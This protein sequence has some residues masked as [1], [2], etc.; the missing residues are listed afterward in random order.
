MSKSDDG[1]D[2]PGLRLCCALIHGGCQVTIA[3]LVAGE[4]EFEAELVS[5]VLMARKRAARERSTLQ[6]FE[7]EVNTFLTAVKYIVKAT[8]AKDLDGDQE[9]AD[10]P[11][12]KLRNILTGQR[13]TL[14]SAWLI[15]FLHTYPINI[16][17]VSRATRT[18]A[19]NRQDLEPRPADFIK[20]TVQ[21][22]RGCEKKRTTREGSQGQQENGEALSDD[23]EVVS[24]T[25]KGAIEDAGAGEVREYWTGRKPLAGLPT[26]EKGPLLENRSISTMLV[27]F[28]DKILDISIQNRLIPSFEKRFSGLLRMLRNGDRLSAIRLQYMYQAIWLH[29]DAV[30]QQRFIATAQ[31]YV[32]EV[33]FHILNRWTEKYQKHQNDAS[34]AD[35]S[36]FLAIAFELASHIELRYNGPVTVLESRAND[37]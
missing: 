24:T 37:G 23:I 10:R 22:L 4:P 25:R 19:K 28:G 7:D 36:F 34:L 11:R 33:A 21:I 26:L 14:K 2:I 3:D 29:D 35:H 13:P 30:Q 9:E 16:Y 12:E 6:E 17:Q 5:K 27:N 15:D 31:E 32:D 20:A 1:H 8:A 18:A